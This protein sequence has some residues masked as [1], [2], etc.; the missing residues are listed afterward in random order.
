MNIQHLNEGRKA[1]FELDG[2]ELTLGNLVIDLAEEQRDNERVISVFAGTDGQLSLEGDTYAAVIVIP[3][4]RY[5]DE[6]VTEMIDS[7]EVTQI[8]PVPQPCSAEAVTLQL[9]AMPE[10]PETPEQSESEE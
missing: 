3:P 5:V 6:E 2:C 10:N 8:I 9:W 4:R 7:E 1:E